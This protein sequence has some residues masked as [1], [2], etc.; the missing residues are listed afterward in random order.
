MPPVEGDALHAAALE[1]AAAVPG[2]PFVEIGSYCGRSTIW[3][4][5]AARQVGTIV[6]AVDHHRGSQENQAG[7]EHHDPEVVDERTGR[8]DTLPFFRSALYD[9]GL[10]D[11]AVAVVGQSPRVAD[12]WPAHSASFVFID[13]GHGAE[14]ATADYRGVVARGGH[15]WHVG[16]P[17]RVPRPRRRRAAARTRTSSSL[18]SRAAGSGWRPPPGR[19][20]SSSGSTGSSCRD[21]KRLR[22]SSGRR[23]RSAAVP[24]FDAVGVPEGR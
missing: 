16:D 24:R 8:M 10:E 3:L 1:A 14:P 22:G 5:A 18:P 19:C 6:F 15:W 7:W 17:R 4:A 12:H 11:H 9:A 20:G 13:G 23:I 21:R 2:K